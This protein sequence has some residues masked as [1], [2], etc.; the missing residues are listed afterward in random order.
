MAGTPASA[1]SFL[2]DVRIDSHA[3][4]PTFT[5]FTFRQIWTFDLPDGY[6]QFN[7]SSGTIGGLSYRNRSGYM[8]QLGGMTDSPLRAELVAVTGPTQTRQSAI[9]A[10]RNTSIYPALNYSSDAY[11]VKFDTVDNRD[12]IVGAYREY[13]TYRVGLIKQNSASL[14]SFFSDID[15][16][17]EEGVAKLLSAI[18]PLGYTESAEL[19]V[20]DPVT[21]RTIQRQTASYTG[22]ATFRGLATVSPVPEPATW[23]MFIGGFG[24]IGSAMRRRQRVSVTFA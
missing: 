21:G 7:D 4:D 5:P 11:S 22:I 18:G 15:S 10:T 1:A 9:N 14:F 20:L 8:S 12:V 19:L 13:G 2:F 24:L 16:Y 23:A 6:G 3:G 17:D